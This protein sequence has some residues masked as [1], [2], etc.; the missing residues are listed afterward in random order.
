MEERE[1]QI[2]AIKSNMEL[3]DTDEIFVVCSDHR[4]SNINMERIERDRWR[5]AEVSKASITNTRYRTLFGRPQRL[6]S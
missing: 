5:N 3:S 2:T 4:N 1:E 6:E